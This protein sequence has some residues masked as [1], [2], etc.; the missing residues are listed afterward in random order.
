MTSLSASARRAPNFSNRDF[1]PALGRFLEQDPV[2]FDGG[3]TNL[4]R[5][6]R[7]SPVDQIDPSGLEITTKPRDDRYYVLD[8][9]NSQIENWIENTVGESKGKIGFRIRYIDKA[10]EGS[11][12]TLS[13]FTEAAAKLCA[14]SVAIYIGH[15]PGLPEL[16]NTLSGIAWELFQHS[17]YLAQGKYWPT[18]FRLLQIALPNTELPT[19][20]A[21]MNV[22]NALG[23]TAN[24]VESNLKVRFYGCLMGYYNE[25]VSPGRRLLTAIGPIA[26]INGF[27]LNKII[28]N[29]L[30]DIK[31][32]LESMLKDC[33]EGVCVTIY[34]G[35]DSPRDPKL[36]QQFAAFTGRAAKRVAGT[37]CSKE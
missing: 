27:E 11:S 35:E 4:Y 3:D 23:S 18:V 21:L 1:S 20:G 25:A 13:Q 24:K 17:K 36:G 10:K 16:P 8:L 2:S 15:G 26:S 29:D 30:K 5:Y 22:I 28:E 33:G 31:A 9:A 19:P 37:P 6:V 14:C 7:N 34:I 32:S 12:S